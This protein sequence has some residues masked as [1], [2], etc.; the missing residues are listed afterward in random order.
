MECTGRIERSIHRRIEYSLSQRVHSGSAH[1]EIHVVVAIVVA[2]STDCS[3]AVA[4][5]F[6]LRQRVV[7]SS[8]SG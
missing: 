3:A 8:D 4:S 2:Q 6:K 1:S 7:L 5:K